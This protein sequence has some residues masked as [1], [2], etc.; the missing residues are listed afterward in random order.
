M[1]LPHARDIH[2]HALTP[3]VSHLEHELDHRTRLDAQLLL[4]R[5]DFEGLGVGEVPLHPRSKVPAMDDPSRGSPDNSAPDA[6]KQRYLELLEH[7]EWSLESRNGMDLGEQL[8][9]PRVVSVKR[10]HD[11]PKDGA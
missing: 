9:P 5:R 1:P 6:L 7:P 11:Q 8:T 2:P 4:L 10:E 3:T